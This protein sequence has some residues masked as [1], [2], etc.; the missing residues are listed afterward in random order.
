VP[1]GNDADLANAA[2]YRELGSR[3]RMGYERD[4]YSTEQ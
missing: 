3:E 2:A 4:W 1:D